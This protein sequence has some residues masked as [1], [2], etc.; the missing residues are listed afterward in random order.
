M[1]Y[2]REVFKLPDPLLEGSGGLSK[3]ASN[4]YHPVKPT[5]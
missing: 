2:D 4:P 3:L 1:E 5:Y